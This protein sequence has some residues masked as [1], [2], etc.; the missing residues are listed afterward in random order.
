MVDIHCSSWMDLD[1]RPFG[2][3]AD[4]VEDC[5]GK[6]RFAAEGVGEGDDYTHLRTAWPLKR[7]CSSTV[8]DFGK[9]KYGSVLVTRGLGFRV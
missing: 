5:V 2:H 7:P 9:R 1:P 4:R 6:G 3:V 8:F